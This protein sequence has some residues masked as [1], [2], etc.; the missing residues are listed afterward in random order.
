MKKNILTI[1]LLVSLLAVGALT[2]NARKEENAL[3]V[4]DVLVED[5][6]NEAS[7]R[8]VRREANEVASNKLSNVKAQISSVTEANTRHIRFVAALDS[9]LYEEVSFTITASNGEETKTLVNNEVVT[10]AY[11]HVEAN[12][13][14]LSASEAFGE[15]YTYLVAYTINNVPESAWGF[16]FSATVNARATGYD[17]SV[18]QSATRV[19]SD[20]IAVEDEMNVDVWDGSVAEKITRGSGTEEDPYVVTSGAELAFFSQNSNLADYSKAYYK[21]GRDLDLNN[22]SWTPIGSSVAF[23]G[24][25]DGNGKSIIGLNT[26]VSTGNTGLFGLANGATIQNLE[27]TGT[28][29]S[30]SNYNSI[31]LARGAAVAIKNCVTKGSV[32]NSKQFAGG[33]V[34]ILNAGATGTKSIIENCTNYADISA[35]DYG[36]GGI[37]G[38]L[39]SG[40]VVEISNCKNYGDMNYTSHYVGGIVGRA[41]K[42]EGSFIKNCYNFGDVLQN[43]S[44]TTS[45]TT[46]GGIIGDNTIKVEN[47]YNYENAKINGYTGLAG[48]AIFHSNNR[49]ALATKNA[50]ICGYFRPDATTD[51]GFINCGMCDIDGNIILSGDVD[52]YAGNAATSIALGEGTLENPY[53]I[54]SG[55][56]LAFMAQKV[57]AKDTTYAHAYYKLTKNLHLNNKSWT[58]IGLQT[59]PFQGHF[60]GNG[61][62]IMGLSIS[63]AGGTGLFGHVADAY[64]MD[65]NVIGNVNSTGVNSGILVGRGQI[66]TISNCTTR[67]SIVSTAGYIGT[68]S[69]SA[70]NYQSGVSG[71]QTKMVIN[72]CTNYATVTCNATGTAYAG[73]IIAAHNVIIELDGCKN[74]GNV[75]STGS[76]AGGIIG[77]TNGNFVGSFIKN[78]SNYGDITSAN[79]LY[80]GG[81]AGISAF[82]LENCYVDENVKINGVAFKA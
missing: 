14:T 69:A 2:N 63:R 58:P 20:M 72:N 61:N 23:G 55:A 3:E 47:C 29:G 59:N 66:S 81:I 50:M 12:E 34:S 16:S 70:N 40:A 30:S 42:V 28:I 64:I 19:I 74:Y 73:G 65:L 57:N 51:A 75:T 45:V 38:Y 9:Y 13:A 11:T 48:T 6:G 4:R 52:S 43:A 10:T 68:I 21:L 76:H 39:N 71:T 82:T 79:S 60:D 78:C 7:G 77:T 1:G 36:V 80:T 44:S 8:L 32:T 17:E 25:F 49:T 53:Q 18:S 54:S 31:L 33:I 37:T 15:G 67:G 41:L 56:E 62:T 27:V 5:F 22:I 26:S 35:S 46:C 24:T